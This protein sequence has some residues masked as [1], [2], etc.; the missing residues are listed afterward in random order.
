MW[1]SIGVLEATRA[2]VYGLITTVQALIDS[3]VTVITFTLA[4]TSWIEFTDN[5]KKYTYAQYSY[6]YGIGYMA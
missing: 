5:A 6:A 1:A 3:A 2:V 4:D